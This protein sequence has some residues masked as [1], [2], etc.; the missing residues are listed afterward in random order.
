[1]TEAER[2]RAESVGKRQSEATADCMSL[3]SNLVPFN[4]H[5]GQAARWRRGLGGG[6]RQSRGGGRGRWLK[7]RGRG[8]GISGSDWLAA[9][10]AEMAGGFS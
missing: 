3:Y 4:P 6:E 7:G 10:A 9:R 2:L 1:M 5:T 8:G